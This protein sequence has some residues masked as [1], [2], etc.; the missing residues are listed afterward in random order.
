VHFSD[1]IYLGHVEHFSFSSFAVWLFYNKGYDAGSSF[2]TVPVFLKD[3]TVIFSGFPVDYLGY[4]YFSINT[5][6]SGSC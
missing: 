5:I 3:F 1:I 4:F 6:T 2:S